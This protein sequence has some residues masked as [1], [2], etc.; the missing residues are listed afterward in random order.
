[1][2]KIETQSIGLRT[3]QDFLNKY[4]ELIAQGWTR[5]EG[6]AMK[7]GL[8][9][10]QCGFKRDLPKEPEPAKAADKK[11]KKTKNKKDK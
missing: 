1:M 6:T 9:G 10:L 3:L 4:D 7:T 8:G 5:S 2:S 11:S